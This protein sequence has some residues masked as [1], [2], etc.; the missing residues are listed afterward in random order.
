[1]VGR[2]FDD[3][4]DE[5]QPIETAGKRHLRLVPVLV[6]QLG[7]GFVID[8]RRVGDDEVVATAFQRGEQV[9]M[10]EADPAVAEAVDVDRGHVQRILGEVDGVDRRVRKDHGGEDGEAARAGADVGDRQDVVGIADQRAFALSGEGFRKQQLADERARHDDAR[11]DDKGHAL[12]IGLAD[13]IGRRNAF[14]D[15]PVDT[16]DDELAFGARQAGIEP[17][18]DV[19][20]RQVQRLEDQE[21]RIVDRLARAMADADL[22]GAVAAHG[23]AQEIPDGEKVFGNF[24]HGDVPDE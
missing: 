24:G 10:M 5:I 1:M 20:D 22:G 16:L 23:V 6:G 9:T 18:I 2:R 8:V 7:H 21:H 11:I 12:D 17:G 14:V 13:Q 3:A 19:V 4:A 15:A